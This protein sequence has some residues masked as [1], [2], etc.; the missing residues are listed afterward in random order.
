MVI[1]LQNERLIILKSR[2]N[3]INTSLYRFCAVDSTVNSAINSA[4]NSMANK[5]MVLLFYLKFH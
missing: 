5:K 4:I 3:R 2:M 1:N